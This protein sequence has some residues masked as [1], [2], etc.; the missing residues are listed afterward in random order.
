V[1]E[2][3]DAQDAALDASLAAADAKFGFLIDFVGVLRALS[4]FEV[5][6]DPPSREAWLEEV[7]EWVANRAAAGRLPG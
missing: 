5:L 2:L 1:T 3:I 7:D 4:E 6:L